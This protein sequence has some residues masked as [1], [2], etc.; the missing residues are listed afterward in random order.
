M[1][2]N[3]EKK[4]AD[5]NAKELSQWE[6]QSDPDPEKRMPQHI[7]QMLNAK[8]LKE[9][10]DIEKALNEAYNTIPTKIDYEQKIVKFQNA[11]D[12]LQ[13]DK[14][15]AAE[16][17]RLL[18]AC[19]DRIEYHRERP[20]RVNGVGSKGKWSDEPMDVTVKKNI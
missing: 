20:H 6:A 12:A 11:L 17:N 14:K 18:K 19:I 4:L 5:L 8:L 9:R 2:K 10:E 3:L 13:D 15:S 1:I 7:F 16:K